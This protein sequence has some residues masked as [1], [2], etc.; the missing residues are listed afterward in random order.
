MAQSVI[1]GLEGLIITEQEEKFFSEVDPFG[2]ILFA[3]NIETP[4]QVKRLTASLRDLVGREDCLILVDQEGGR[5]AR[6]KPP[7]WRQAHPAATF[8]ALYQTDHEA[9]IEAAKLNARLFADELESLGVN[10]DCIPMLDVRASS[11][12]EIIGD[13]AFG[14]DPK[15][16]SILGRAAAEG[17]LEGGVLPIIKHIPGHG[18]AKVDSHHAVPVIKESLETLAE[19]DF[20]PFRALNDL[21]LAMTGHLIFENIDNGVVST[22]SAKLIDEVIRNDGPYGIG[23]EGLLMTDDLSMGALG[24]SFESRTRMSLAAGCDI[25]LHCNGEMLEMAAIANEL[26]PLEGLALTRAERALTFMRPP[27]DFVREAELERLNEL[28][29]GQYV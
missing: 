15:T 11:A 16:V 4:D 2:F 17:L 13:R 6:F 21:P 26:K 23:F 19:W 14:D 27:T 5:V 20:K 7:H 25:V 9:G 8:G 29:L 18:R 1:F 10:V 3:R 22:L 12:D 24:G 28:L